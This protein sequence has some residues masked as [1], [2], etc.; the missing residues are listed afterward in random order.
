MK[1]LNIFITLAL[2]IS[3]PLPGYSDDRKARTVTEN[4]WILVRPLAVSTDAIESPN[5]VRCYIGV[6]YEANGIRNAAVAMSRH[7]LDLVAIAALVRAEATDGDNEE[8][9]LAIIK[10][11]TD[12]FDQFS[13]IYI[14]GIEYELFN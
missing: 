1:Y 14:N 8:I 2:F 4:E 10:I 13:H 11:P 12:T 6:A 7:C 9:K 3:I 5:G